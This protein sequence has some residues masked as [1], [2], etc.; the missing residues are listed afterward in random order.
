MLV[1]PSVVHSVVGS[2]TSG[3]PAGLRVAAA[4]RRR[5]SGLPALCCNCAVLVLLRMHAQPVPYGRSGRL[6]S[7]NRLRHG[8]FGR[9]R[10]RCRAGS[11]HDARSNN[12]CCQW[13]Q[14]QLN[15]N[16]WLVAFHVRFESRGDLS[17]CRTASLRSTRGCAIRRCWP[18]F[19]AA[20]NASRLEL[21]LLQCCWPSGPQARAA[22]AGAG[23]GAFSAVHAGVAAAAAEKG[24]VVTVSST[25]HR[26]TVCVRAVST[27]AG[28]HASRQ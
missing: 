13:Q 7:H 15:H 22:G 26:R 11:A 16:C 18:S 4:A 20:P 17:M 1:R 25:Y 9:A 14:P 19:G 28:T 8:A 23:A 2:G 21:Q 24:R 3:L 6:Q 12:N 27:Y 10:V 5:R